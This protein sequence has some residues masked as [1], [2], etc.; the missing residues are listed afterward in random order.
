MEREA[1]NVSGSLVLRGVLA[2]IFG[3]AAVFWPGIT[4]LTLV[5][6]FSAFIL[7]NGVLDLVF[8]I[9]R[10]GTS[11]MSVWTRVL[12]LLFGIVQ[13]GVGVYLLRHPGVGFATFILLIGFTLLIRGVFEIV[14]GLFEDGSAMYRVVMIVGGLLAALAGILVL[15]QPAAGGVAFVWILGVYALITGPLMIALAMDIN[16][17]SKEL[18]GAKPI[19]VK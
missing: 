13:V 8:G 6:L 16:R 11:S 4:L 1:A 17:Q 5:Y 2:L 10:L 19:R 18:S 7:I 15:F 3:V 12:P 9:T 14:E